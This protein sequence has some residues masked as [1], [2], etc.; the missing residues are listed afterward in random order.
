MLRQSHTPTHKH[1][2]PIDTRGSCQQGQP[3][4]FTTIPSSA[5]MEVAQSGY[6]GGYGGASCLQELS[7]ESRAPGSDPRVPRPFCGEI[8]EVGATPSTI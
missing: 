7:L 3:A 8:T 6:G 4:L 5:P 1:T 2:H